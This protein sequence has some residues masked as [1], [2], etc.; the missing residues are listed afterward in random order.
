MQKPQQFEAIIIGG[1]YAGLAAAMSLGRALK[2]ILVIDSG[3]P[4]NRQTPY[5]H[6]FLTQDG[7]A[8]REIAERAKKQV[9]AYKNVKFYNGIATS[10]KKVEKGFEITTGIGDIFFAKKLI[11]ATG[12]NDQSPNIEGF[13]VCWGISVLHCPFCHGY[14]VRS[15]MTGILSSGQNAYELAVLISNW[16]HQLIIFTNGKHDL[17]QEQLASLKRR[18]I[19]INQKQ[20][21]R[22]DHT[23]GKLEQILFSDGTSEKIKAIYSRNPF[24]QHCQIPQILGCEPTEDGYIKVDKHMETS[25]KGVYACGDNVTKVRTV[26]N[27]VASGTTA[28][29]MASKSLISEQF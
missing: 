16:T 21:E 24:T 29:M 25:I 14:E 28:G 15:E 19:T 26:A 12:I 6:N 17:T 22:F 7:T 1:S 11:F 8:P 10:G 9:S 4:C 27:A 13:S 5:S 20:V 18:S 3:K 23:N 2:D